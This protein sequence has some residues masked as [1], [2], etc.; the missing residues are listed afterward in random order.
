MEASEVLRAAKDSLLSNKVRSSL[1]MLGVIIGVTAVILLVSI[2]TGARNYIHRELSN[3][4]TNIL[5]VL[6][7]KVA[8]RGGFHPPAAG[9]TRK[10]TIADAE[11]LERRSKYLSN[12]VPIA[13]GTSKV[14]FLNQSRDTTVVGATEDYFY[15][16][17]LQSELGSYIS[18]ADVETKRRVCVLGRTV[19]REL[20]GDANPLGRCVTI[21]DSRFRV[22]GVMAKKGVTLGLDLDDVVFIPTTTAQEFFDT[23]SLFQIVTKVKSS[24]EIQDAINEI[25]GI[26]MKRHANKEDFTIMSQDEMLEAMAKVLN[27]MTAVLAGIAAISLIVGGIGIMNIMLVSVRE[28]TRE[29]GLRKAVGAKYRDILLQFLTESVTLS[30]IGGSAGIL[31]GIASALVIPLFVT[32]LPT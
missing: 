6:P 22:I 3:L 32:F 9:T 27:I 19:K 28:R 13:L 5:V 23:D 8:T 31:L 10:L 11:A 20:F 4:G 14:K 12:A 15:V 16:R 24:E 21:G 7:G 26:L 29:I 18:Q 2:G 25:K 1:T 30:L 17:N